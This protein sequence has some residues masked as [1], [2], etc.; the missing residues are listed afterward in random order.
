MRQRVLHRDLKP[1]NILLDDALGARI[2]D[3]GL[4]K[5][6]VGAEGIQSA[7]MTGTVPYMAPEV[8]PS[9]VTVTVTVTVIAIMRP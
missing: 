7:G 3:F 2:A 4:S 1:Q 8:C 9:P 5:N 6:N